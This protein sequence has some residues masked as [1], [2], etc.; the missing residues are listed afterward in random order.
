MSDVD[1]LA[2]SDA[3]YETLFG[4]HAPKDDFLRHQTTLSV[5]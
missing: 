4:R 3:T 5:A 2:R 1:R